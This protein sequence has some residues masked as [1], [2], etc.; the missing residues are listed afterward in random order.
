V[1]D[2]AIGTDQTRKFVYVVEADN[3]AK[4]VYVTLGSVFDGRRVVKD[5]LTPESR[6]VVNG[7]MRVRPGIKVTPQE[8]GAAPPVP[9]TPTAA[10]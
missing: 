7:L 8:E 3:S 2:S 10:K 1:P 5:G 9:G 6:V 4:Q